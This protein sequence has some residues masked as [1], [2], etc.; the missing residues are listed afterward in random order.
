MEVS[1]NGSTPQLSSIYGFDELD[2]PAR[3]G[4]PDDYGPPQSW[5]NESQLRTSF[6]HITIPGVVFEI[7]TT[8]IQQVPTALGKPDQF[9]KE[10]VRR[11]KRKIIGTWGKSLENEYIGK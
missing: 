11:I 8:S 5:V 9:N 1:I 4:Y 2:H 6:E 7:M 3:K 10:I